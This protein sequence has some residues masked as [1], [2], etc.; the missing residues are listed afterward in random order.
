MATTNT[1]ASSGTRPGGRTVDAATSAGSGSC[2]K[3]TSSAEV[4]RRGRLPALGS[5][6]RRH[7]RRHQK[8][9]EAGCGDGYRLEDAAL[10]KRYPTG[11]STL[12][13]G[14]TAR[15]VLRIGEGHSEALPGATGQEPRAWLRGLRRQ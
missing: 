13:N 7:W 8:D 15:F 12:R 2:S 14:G 10:H 5:Q 11:H 9:R 3:L 1:R 4:T 6:V